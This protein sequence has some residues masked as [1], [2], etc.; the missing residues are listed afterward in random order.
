MR[1][2]RAVGRRRC[3]RRRRRRRMERW[4]S[5]DR[6]RN[7][8]V[9][10]REDSRRRVERRSTLYRFCPSVGSCR[11][12][13]V[14]LPYPFNR[15]CLVAAG[16][17]RW[18]SFFFL[19]RFQSSALFGAPLAACYSQTP[20]EARS[21]FARLPLPLGR[22]SSSFFLARSRSGQNSEHPES[23]MRTSSTATAAL[24]G[25]QT[26]TLLLAMPLPPRPLYK[27]SSKIHPPLLRKLDQPYTALRPLPLPALSSLDVVSPGRSTA[28]ERRAGGG[29]GCRGGDL[30]L[31]TVALGV[32]V[33]EGDREK[34]KTV[35]RL[36]EKETEGGE[37]GEGGGRRGKCEVCEKGE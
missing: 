34:G 37:G 1:G 21:T 36:R 27:P 18:S 8:G 22:S 26:R 17:R 33:G 24:P 7:W 31:R 28:S 23:A 12:V 11:I 4:Q 32:D 2:V 15:S 5:S 30:R 6:T 35:Q 16:R 3:S 13:C 29:R 14:N 10:R 9:C 19:C 20:G 25:L